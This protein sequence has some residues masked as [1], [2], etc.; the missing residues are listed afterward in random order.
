M[1]RRDLLRNLFLA[2]A[3]TV[4]V[5]K[6]ALAR[7]LPREEKIN[8]VLAAVEENPCW[9]WVAAAVSPLQVRAILG[10]ILGHYGIKHLTNISQ[11]E[12]R[13][14]D[15]AQT[16]LLRGIGD[17]LKDS[18]KGGPLEDMVSVVDGKTYREPRY[19]RQ[20]SKP[21]EEEKAM[22]LE[23]LWRYHQ[24]IRGPIERRVA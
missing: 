2:P 8:E 12:Y 20:F 5:P 22:A 23:W 10:H 4:V 24:L 13:L 7:E 16:V 6:V 14:A 19:L 3:A 9:A 11:Q 1:N 15:T 21:T 17:V 18:A